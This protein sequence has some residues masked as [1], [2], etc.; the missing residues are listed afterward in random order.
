MKIE[1]DAL[2]RPL[3]V[4]DICVLTIRITRITSHETVRDDLGL[5][6]HD[7]WGICAEKI[8]PKTE[9]GQGGLTDLYGSQLIKVSS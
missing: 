4:G 3:A 5:V 7:G 8:D 6:V 1:K 9:L 2:G